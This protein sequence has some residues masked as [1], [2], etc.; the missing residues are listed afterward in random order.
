MK[1]IYLE[2]ELEKIP[3]DDE[4]TPDEWYKWCEDHGF[5]AL[6]SGRRGWSTIMNTYIRNA[7]WIVYLD[8]TPV[9]VFSDEA[10]EEFRY[11]GKI[12]E[13]TRTIPE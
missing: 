9:D 6:A 12:D 13:N 3:S 5:Y 2:C 10:I 8:S 7:N 11:K 1:K 4:V